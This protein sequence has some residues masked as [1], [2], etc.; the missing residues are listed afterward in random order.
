[1]STDSPSDKASDTA[2]GTGQTK[3]AVLYLRVSTAEQ[4]HG[5]GASEGYS[6]P[7]QRDACRKK[8]RDLGAAVVEE[9][10]D[11]GESARSAA[12]PQLQRM[13]RLLA[14]HG[15]I[16]YVIVHKID[17]LARN[18]ADDV[19]IQL[20]IQKAGAQVVSVTENVDET[21]SGQLVR[22]IMADLAEFYS[23]NLA[24]EILKGSTQKARMGGTPYQ[25]PIGYLN[26]R[27]LVEGREIRT[28]EIDPERA[29]FVRRAYELYAT[30]EYSIRRLHELLTAEG[31]TARPG[32]KRPARPLALSKFFEVLRNRYYLGVVP[33][34]GVEHPGKHPALI[35]ATLFEQVQRVLDEREQHALKPRRHQ[36]YLR[37]LLTCGRCGGRLMYTTGRGRH[38]EEFDYYICTKRHRGEGCTLRYLPAVDVDKRI[39]RAWA[40]WVHLAQIDGEAAG[41]ML[42]EMLD[43]K[44]DHAERLA[45][46]R[47]RLARLDA[48]R[49]K[50][51]QMAY[52]DAIPLDLL[53]TEQDRITRERAQAERGA[54]DAETSGEQAVATFHQAAAL[55]ERGA[56]VYR[57]GGPE[58]RRLLN[59]S[60]FERIVV[61][62]EGERATLASPWREI[63]EAADQVRELTNRPSPVSHPNRAADR[64]GSTPNPGPLHEDRG[65]TMNHLVELRGFEPLTPSMRTRCATRLRY[66]PWCLLRISAGVLGFA[67]GYSLAARRRSRLGSAVSIS[68]KD[69]SSSSRA[70]TDSG[71]AGAIALPT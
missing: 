67:N 7:A 61:D 55:M 21:P 47:R 11:R 6:I 37:G 69:G 36:H 32:P 45:R 38:G 27:Y 20:A 58:V 65:S 53:K 13:L 24:T 15:G 68:A 64:R 40:G 4:A 52:A 18:R 9:F 62:D 57:R 35:G 12:R 41:R 39:T 70:M 63:R 60:F 71:R 59:R 3:R 14:E 51:V 66:S 5:D 48:E 29:P 56:E 26:V 17:R 54:A 19:E 44:Q 34:R 23:K 43:G 28:V 50:L 10:P 16:D 31:L 49:L 8:A 33:Y 42:A 30:G 1:M 2:F 25:A 46:A 22:N